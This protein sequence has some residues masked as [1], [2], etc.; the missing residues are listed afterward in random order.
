MVYVWWWNSCLRFRITNPEDF[1]T[2]TIVENRKIKSD[3]S[4]KFIVD[5]KERVN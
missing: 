1:E 2:E 3:G 5:G 4:N